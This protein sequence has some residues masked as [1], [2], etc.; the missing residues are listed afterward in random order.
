MMDSG[1][2]VYVL[3]KHYFCFNY[4]IMHGYSTIGCICTLDVFSLC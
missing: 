1:S 4:E 3:A 2:D